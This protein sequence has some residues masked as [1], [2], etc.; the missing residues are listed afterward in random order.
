MSRVDDLLQELLVGASMSKQ[1]HALDRHHHHASRHIG[2]ANNPFQ[3]HA[4][5]GFNSRCSAQGFK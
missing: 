5:L 1:I 4:G 3:H 2:H